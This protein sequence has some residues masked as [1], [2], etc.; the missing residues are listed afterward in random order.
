MNA[1]KKSLGSALVLALTTLLVGCGS[2]ASAPQAT[3]LKVG[4]SGAT[5]KVGSSALTIP[6]GA[7]SDDVVIT[8]REVEP[9]HAAR[10]V[11][12]ELEPA[13]HPLA[14]PAMLSVKLDDSNARV[15]MMESETETEHLMEVEVEDHARHEYKTSLSQLGAVEVELEH[16]RACSTACAAN[17]ECDDGACKPHVED[18]AGAVC[19][20]V[21]GSG[22]ECDDGACKPH[23]G[24]GGTAP[25][26]GTATC[27]PGCATGLEC[28]NGICK[29]HNP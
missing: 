13:G 6:A 16:L 9:H 18:A 27:T 12:V 20:E 3:T 15:K 25:A 23:G 1:T 17:E 29:P 10:A 5:L 11:R 28:D 19:S 21:C 2:G 26:P 14:K 8:L 24:A 7:L 4:A 22:L